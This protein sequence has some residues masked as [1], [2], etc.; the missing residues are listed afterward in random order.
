MKKRIRSFDDFIN[1]QKLNEGEFSR[2]IA[3]MKKDSQK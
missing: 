3:Y 1:E 2:V